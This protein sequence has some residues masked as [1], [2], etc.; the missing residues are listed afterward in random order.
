MYANVNCKTSHTAEGIAGSMYD[1]VNCKSPHVAEGIAER[2]SPNGNFK[3]PHAAEGI[4]GSMCANVNCKSPHT[5]EGI[6]GSMYV[7]GSLPSQ[8][9][10][11]VSRILSDENT[12]AEWFFDASRTGVRHKWAA[13]RKEARTQLRDPDFL[14][15][16]AGR[17]GVAVSPERQRLAEW[18]FDE[19]HTELMFSPPRSQH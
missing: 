4:A 8:A 2:M 13:D 6:A 11:G 12:K 15:E 1:N 10:E 7:N 14:A 17:G 3:T 18:F 5:A 9:G 19:S 16:N